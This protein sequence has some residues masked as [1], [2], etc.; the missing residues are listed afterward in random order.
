MLALYAFCRRPDE[1][2]VYVT[3]AGIVF[4]TARECLNWKSLSRV[5]KRMAHNL[6]TMMVED[7]YEGE[8]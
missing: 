6:M 5:E 7:E 4:L 1:D 3:E 2:Y 8:A